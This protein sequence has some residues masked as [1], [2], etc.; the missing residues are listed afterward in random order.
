M[1]RLEPQNDASHAR[2]HVGVALATVAREV[3]GLRQAALH[4]IRVLF[5]DFQLIQTLELARADL[6]QIRIH[7]WFGQHTLAEDDARRL[8]RALQRRGV[9]GCKRVTARRE[10]LPGARRL[11]TPE[12]AQRKVAP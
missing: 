1:A 7:L 4:E 11:L 12:R 9:D 2:L 6:R 8:E 3:S 5:A 10:E